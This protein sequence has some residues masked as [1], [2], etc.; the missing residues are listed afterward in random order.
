[1]FIGSLYF[2]ISK[3]ISNKKIKVQ[4]V[5]LPFSRRFI[6][7]ESITKRK[8]ELVILLDKYFNLCA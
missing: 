5:F 4:S 7:Y 2:V 3:Y 6:V 8:S 1:M